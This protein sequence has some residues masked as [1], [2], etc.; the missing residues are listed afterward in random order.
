MKNVLQETSNHFVVVHCGSLISAKA[1]SQGLA[2]DFQTGDH[3]P[4]DMKKYV[5]LLCPPF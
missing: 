5:F 1:E 4:Q 2:G 3:S